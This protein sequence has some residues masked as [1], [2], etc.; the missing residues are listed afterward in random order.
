MKSKLILIGI[1]AAG[2]ALAATLPTGPPVHAGLSRS[3]ALGYIADYTQRMATGSGV[4]TVPTTAP[5]H[6]GI[7]HNDLL[8]YIA[9]SLQD[10]AE[11]GGGGSGAA[12]INAQTGTSYTLLSGD[13]GKIIVLTNASAITLT[14]PSGL[15]QGFHCTFIQGGAGIVTVETSSTTVNSFGSLLSTA[16]QHAAASLIATAANVF[17]LSGNLQ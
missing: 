1:I 7:N 15:G 13:L 4:A 3:D 12:S 5:V 2:F 11:S 10:L 17:T 9:D 16:G 8:A 14:V 6:S